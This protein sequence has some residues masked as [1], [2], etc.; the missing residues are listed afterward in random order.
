MNASSIAENTKNQEVKD[1]ILVVDDIPANVGVLFRFLTDNGFKTLVAKN[2]EQALKL[3]KF[4]EPKIILLDVMMPGMD[5]FEVCKIVKS[6]DKTKDIPVIF[7]TA[8]TDTV[9][10]VKGFDLGAVDYITKPFQ[11]EEILARVTSHIKVYKLQQ[12]LKE[13]NEHLKKL[14]EELSVEKKKSDDLLLNILPSRI[15][16]NLKENG[17]TEPETFDNV[18]VCFSDFIGFTELSS[19][20]EPRI[21]IKELNN[22]F[23]NF[24]NI[25]DSY[26]CERI[27]TIGDAYLCVCGMP[28]EHPKHAESVVQAAIEFI[29]YLKHRNQHS[30]IQWCTRIG[31]HT[32]KVIGGVV[33]IKK[34]IYDV[35]GDTI[36]TAARMESCSESMKIN[37]SEVTYQIVK[38]KFEI[39]QRGTLSVKGKGEMQMYF[40]TPMK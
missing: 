32:G 17:K 30:E 24:D 1:I 39:E 19:Q 28:D 2:G 4:A 34:Y 7:M 25:I 27:K 13:Q 35:F 31:I 29:D 8:L 26:Q 11:Q 16:Y 37:I 23:T 3:L 21:L 22:I 33:G 12:L 38:D 5:G 10:K 20:L 40:V 18:T 6:E 14:N 15:A 36:N 9:D